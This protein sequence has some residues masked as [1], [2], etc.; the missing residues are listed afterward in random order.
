A[1][2]ANALQGGGLVVPETMA[3]G[4]PF[5]KSWLGNGEASLA[6]GYQSVEDS[7]FQRQGL[8]GRVAGSTVAFVAGQPVAPAKVGRDLGRQRRRQRDDLRVGEDLGARGLDPSSAGFGAGAEAPGEPPGDGL[9]HLRPT[10]G[11]TGLGQFG[12]N[13][14]NRC[15]LGCILATLDRGAAPTQRVRQPSGRIPSGGVRFCPPPSI[16][17]RLVLVGLGLARGVGGPLVLLGP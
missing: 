8:S 15:R 4:R 17:R 11:R 6:A 2:L 10:P 3:P 16:Q 5:Y 1:A 14:G 13:L 7:T 9:G 12:D